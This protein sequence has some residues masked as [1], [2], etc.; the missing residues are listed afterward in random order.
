MYS[1]TGR[2]ITSTIGFGLPH[3]SGRSLVPSPPAIIKPFI[4]RKTPL[5]FVI[6]IIILLST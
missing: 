5:L 4:K 3:V 1:I 6:I 2:P